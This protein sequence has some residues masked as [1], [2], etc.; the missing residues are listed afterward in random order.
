MI[1]IEE[2]K[3]EIIREAPEFDFYTHLKKN[4]RDYK[5]NCREEAK[6]THYCFDCQLSTCK[7]CTGEEHLNHRLQNKLKLNADC[8]E[9]VFDML[10][11]D[12]KDNLHNSNKIKND[13]S[14]NICNYVDNLHKFLDEMKAKKIKEME[15]MFENFEENA[16]SLKEKISEAK[17]SLLNFQTKYK[18][19]FDL[20]NNNKDIENTVFLMHYDMIGSCYQRN[21]DILE[22]MH[23]KLTSYKNFDEEVKTSFE[24]MKLI[25]DDLMRHKSDKPGEPRIN[26]SKLSHDFYRDIIE[27]ID[28]YNEHV[29]MFKKNIFYSFQKNGSLKEIER[30][31]TLYSKKFCND[32]RPSIKMNSDTKQNSGMDLSLNP[33]DFNV[34]YRTE[35]VETRNLIEEIKEDSNEVYIH[36]EESVKIDVKKKD[37]MSKKNSLVK[38]AAKVKYDIVTDKNESLNNISPQKSIKTPTKRNSLNQEKFNSV[39]KPS[40]FTHRALTMDNGTNDCDS[41]VFTYTL[42]SILN[43][44]TDYVP[45]NYKRTDDITLANKILQRYFSFFTLEAVNKHLKFLKMPKVEF[46]ASM[47]GGEAGCLMDYK[48]YNKLATVKQSDN[49]S[50]EDESLID[51]ESFDV[52]KPIEGTNEVQIYDRKKR[53][54]IRK[55]VSLSKKVH[56]CN[57]FL[58]GCRYI[59]HNEKLFITGGRDEYN[60]YNLVLQ[61]D[62]KEQVLTRMA[63]MNYNRSYHTIEFNAMVNSFL[64]IGGE[65]NKTCEVYDIETNQWHPLPELSVGRAGIQIFIDAITSQIYAFFGKLGSITTDIFSDSID[66]LDLNDMDKGWVQVAYNNRSDLDFK[67]Y[68]GIRP[69]FRE[70]ILIIG[71]S[72]GR[73]KV[74]TSAIYSIRKHD[75]IKIDKKLFEEIR[76]ECVKS[77][78][79][80]LLLAKIAV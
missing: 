46:K 51:L 48:N 75:I 16:N 37:P 66:V 47:A 69:L 79:L 55:Q 67:F 80:S 32:H 76:V 62:I 31:I 73:E 54:L 40:A 2:N 9:K 57:V 30:F 70:K 13:F 68:C 50:S 4:I 78:R 27:R 63:D 59:L 65:N 38:Q 41:S 52:A 72:L 7:A 64:V 28:K 60:E 24:R 36:T 34:E 35:G 45:V 14:N 23:S 58:D 6:L 3:D 49:Y 5:L 26:F 21:K 25:S 53:Q 71:T 74:R 11:K 42:N 15:L 43:R 18:K 39:E 12:L 61:F 33:K 8:S 56:G 29:D 20:G 1:N 22:I 17:K 77:P 44:N 19:F 10:E